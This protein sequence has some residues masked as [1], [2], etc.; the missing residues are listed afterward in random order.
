[1]DT[2]G[3][4]NPPKDPG[5]RLKFMGKK[6]TF[7][8]FYFSYCHIFFCI[9]IHFPT[10]LDVGFK[11]NVKKYPGL[12]AESW[13]ARF[14]KGFYFLAPWCPGNMKLQA[15]QGYRPSSEKPFGPSGPT[16]K[17]PYDCIN[18]TARWMLWTNLIQN[19]H[20]QVSARKNDSLFVPLHILANLNHKKRLKS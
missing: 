6:S 7:S 3:P 11:L 8:I 18:A 17:R 1:M 20:Q 12:M 4:F 14:S 2:K 9:F 16:N 19:K 5:Y 13:I 15:P 10:S